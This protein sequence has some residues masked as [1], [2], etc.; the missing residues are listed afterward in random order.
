MPTALPA[1]VPIP[2]CVDLDGTL[3][4]TDLLWESALDVVRREP[5]TVFALPVWLTRGR[6]CLKA[7]LAARARIDVSRLP[8]ND[9]LLDWLRAAYTEG[10]VLFLVTASDR[11]LA[12]KISGH[13]GIFAGV[14]A[15]DGQTNLAGTAKAGR[16]VA[17]FG[18]NGFDYAANGAV[19]VAVWRQARSAVL[20][21][22]SARTRHRAGQVTSVSREFA[23]Q[24]SRGAALLRALRPHQWVKNLIVFVPLLTSHQL[25]SPSLVTTGLL[26]FAAFCLC[27]S[28][29]YLAN[30][31][32]D[33]EA[34]RR[35]P[36]KQHRPF[37]A[38][39]LPLTWAL[40]GTPLLLVAG[41][42]LALVVTPAFALVL[43]CY[44]A[45]AIA[46]SWRLKQTALLDVLVLAALYT[47]RLIAGHAA[48]GVRYSEWLLAFSMFLFVSLALVKRFQEIQAQGALPAT[49]WIPG[50]GYVPG[51]L[52]LLA[53]FGAASGY[54]S[55]M[56]MALYVSSEQVRLLYRQP[57][58]LLLICPLLLYWISRVWLHTH[59]GKM[60]DDPVVFA[61][62]DRVSYAIGAGA[63]GVIW[64][65]T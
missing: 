21:N 57:L 8:F 7:Q 64:L 39:A 46:Y 17:Q 27:A 53:S 54:L 4:R 44:A 42:A 63:L 10:R 49:Q 2:L 52:G 15:S 25:L 20:V 55:V 5:L 35:H 16:L 13:L 37:A 3:L 43:A 1:S 45:L 12:E 41:F 33:L 58:L 9:E 56:V 48:T 14:L 31:V 23:P 62:K 11:A 50:R 65:A 30:D 47:I 22:A 36:A 40:A 26:A 29:I 38:G 51:D 59:R 24:A 34:D 18:E 6:A 60:H 28:A 61:L 32:F 19:D